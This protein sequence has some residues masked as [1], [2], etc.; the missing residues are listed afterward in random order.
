[1][2]TSYVLRGAAVL[3]EAGG[4]SS[5]LDVRVEDGVITS[6]GAGLPASARSIDVAGLWLM[7]GV[8]D[9]HCHVGLS[10]L[11]PNPP[12]TTPITRW[13]IE[14]ARNARVTLEAGV[15]FVR[16]AG[17][18]DAGIRDAIRDCLVQG[19][20]VQVSVVPLT[21]TG[22]H[23]DGWLGGPGLELPVGYLF[24]D[25]PGRPNYRVDG[26]DAM[27]AT[28]RTVLRAG[29]DWIKLCTTGGV[30]SE[31]DALLDSEFTFEEIQAAVSEAARRR[32]GVLAHAYGG[33]G[34]DDAVRAGVRSV[35][36]GAFL[37]EAQAAAM[38]R[39][40]CWFV[41]TLSVMQ[42]IIA[43]A[44]EARLPPDMARKALELDVTPGV[45]EALRIARAHGVRV[46]LG[47]DANSMAMHGRNLGEISLMCRHGM[48]VEEA[49]LTATIRGAEL[50]GV[51]ATRGRIAAGYV[52]DAILLG[53]DPSDPAVF[54]EPST[55]RQVFKAGVAVKPNAV[56][57]S[58]R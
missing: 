49:L 9:C 17:G 4:F 36:H 16:D 19:P 40:D 29:A 32:K 20:T 31:G 28:V 21:Q 15:T 51:Q 18:L 14:A 45:G 50:C 57:A 44:K 22:G 38:A 30:L 24:P 34:I 56:G 39:A 37:T 43:L 41:P 2:S 12:L 42:E 47:T 35:E 27:R 53:S 46:A 8:I 7:P 58:E 5:P 48:P 54:S 1:M 13:V 23:V 10:A 6:V 55:V 3:D 52:F 26:T 33:A 25:Y 11:A